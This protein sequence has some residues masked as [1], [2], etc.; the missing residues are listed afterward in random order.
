MRTLSNPGVYA[1][2]AFTAHKATTLLSQK[3]GK[4]FPV[5]GGAEKRYPPFAALTAIAGGGYTLSSR[6]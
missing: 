1:G 2:N 5:V 3:S 6:I 4:T